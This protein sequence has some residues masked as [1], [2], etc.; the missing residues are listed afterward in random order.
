MTA[1]LTRLLAGTEGGTRLDLAGHLA[2]HGPLELPSRRGVEPWAR[3]LLGEIE[4]SGLA[5]RG[6]GGFPTATKLASLPQG[7][8]RNHLVIN[9]MEGEPAAQKD[10]VLAAFAPHLVLDGAEAL[11]AVIHG[12]SITVA[13][14]RDNPAAASSLSAAM[15]ERA[16]RGRDGVPM[17]IESVPGRY[18]GGEESGL[19][20][21]L[22]GGPAMPTFRPHK[23]ARL[24]VR[25]R[26]A[27]VDNAETA[28]AV[29]LIARRGGAW[30]AE[31]GR[32]GA[33]GSS[34]V[35]LS[36]AVAEQGVFEVALGSTLGEVVALAKPTGTVS[37][38]LLGG[39]GGTFVGPSALDAPYSNEGLRPH[40]ASVGAG[41]I[42]V[43]DTASCG[44]TETARITR[45]MANE[46][47]GQ[48]G[49][50]VFGL[51]AIAEDLE[52][53]AVGRGD[54]RVERQLRNRLKVINGR[55]ACAHPDGVVRMVTSA[56]DVFAGDLTA[57]VGG[58]RCG[59]ASAATQLALPP[60][61]GVLEWR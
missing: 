3:D 51:P 6:G 60:N 25:G 24:V 56:L 18:V 13:V 54:A 7:R 47:A 49:P 10:S 8:R 46:S 20:H 44:I 29:A 26:A 4:R 35:T 31:G 34:L 17:S 2:I 28:A 39:Y 33:A 22:D 61:G 12:A 41:V 32:K 42:V 45:W 55:G 57:H 50:C 15:A 30:F 37:G 5:G 11:A 59:G 52:A 23:P 14:A 53:I 19:V 21:W 16:R 43:L 1:Q 27:I 38:I 48:C 40:G 58:R 9:V 36:G